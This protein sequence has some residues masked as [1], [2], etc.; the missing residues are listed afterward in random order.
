MTI[1]QLSLAEMRFLFDSENGSDI[2]VSY[3]H[4]KNLS[5]YV[6]VRSYIFF[7]TDNDT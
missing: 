6:N 7:R 5:P 3:F 4:K 1:D 2:S